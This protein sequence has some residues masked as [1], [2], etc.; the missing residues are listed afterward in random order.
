LTITKYAFYSFGQIISLEFP[1]KY[2]DISKLTFCF[3][4]PIGDLRI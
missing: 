2:N 1:A 4:I 3:P